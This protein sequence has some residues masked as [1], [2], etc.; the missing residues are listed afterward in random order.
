MK[1][2]L[3]ENQIDLRCFIFAKMN[4]NEEFESYTGEA[5]LSPIPLTISSPVIKPEDRNQIKANAVEAMHHYANQEITMLKR[6]AEV[7]MQQ[8]REIEQRLKIS[9]QIYQS[10]IR[11]V[12]VVNQVYHLYEKQDHYSLSL[13]SPEEW[14]NSR[15]SRKFVASVKL[16]GDH[17]WEMLWIEK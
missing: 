11:F 14:G 16:L 1:I 4:P 6:Q 3:H 9:E 15:H 7:I 12:P 17:S 10:E 8:V 13:V 2:P 5:S